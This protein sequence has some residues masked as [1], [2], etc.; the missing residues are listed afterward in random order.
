MDFAG[1]NAVFLEGYMEELQ[2]SILLG[3]RQVE[4]GIQ[5]VGSQDIH[6][7]DTA[8]EVGRAFHT[9][10]YKL[11]RPLDPL[12]GQ[13]TY[14]GGDEW[15]MACKVSVL[16]QEPSFGGPSSAVGAS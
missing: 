5:V 9:C 12:V 13:D 4:E 15:E 11:P 7:V 6:M 14:L 10:S 8:L 1:L 16:G 3:Q 2:D